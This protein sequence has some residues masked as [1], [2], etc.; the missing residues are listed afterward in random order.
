MANNQGGIY[1]VTVRSSDPNGAGHIGLDLGWSNEQGPCLLRY[2]TIEGFDTG[3]FTNHGV[4]SVTVEFLTLRGQRVVGFDNQGQCVSIR[5]LRSELAVPAFRNARGGVTTL[6]DSE[7]QGTDGAAEV[8]AIENSKAALF[9]RNTTTPGYARAITNNSGHQNGVDATTITEFV[10]HPPLTLF[11]TD[12]HSL[13]LPIED[14]PDVPMDPPAKWANVADFGPPSSIE[15]IDQKSGKRE[16]RPDWTDAIQRAIDSGASTVY[17]PVRGDFGFYG[18]VY[19]R[20]N[21]Q[22]ITALRCGFPSI[23]ASTQHRIRFQ[24]EA[25]PTWVIQ[26]GAGPV[27][28]EDFDNHYF[29]FEVQQQSSRP[30]VLRELLSHDISTQPGAGDIFILDV[31]AQHVDANGGRIFA[32]QLNTEGYREPRNLARDGGSLW[33]LGLKTENDPTVA[34]AKHG[35]QIEILGGFVYANKAYDPEKVMLRI[36]DGGA[37]SATLGEF[38]IRKQPFTPVEQMQGE[39]TR[40]IEH[41]DAPGR[42]GGSMLPLFVARP[43]S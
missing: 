18:K 1:R 15:L 4:N 16:T 38:V 42:G 7:L 30:L 31:V 29:K 11:E 34:H 2:V 37:L 14:A 24:E 22:R 25:M 10:S 8:T 40:R 26:D 28:I 39:Q 21:V 32:R 3:V 12:A 13:G 23:I 6:I 27:V 9:V 43:A 20:G 33:V 41:G 5:G 19:V 17:F 35:G 36:D